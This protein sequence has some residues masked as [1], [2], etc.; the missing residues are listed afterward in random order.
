[1]KRLIATRGSPN[2]I[3]KGV[4]P[5]NAKTKQLSGTKWLSRTYKDMRFHNFLGNESITWKFNLSKAPWQGGQFGRLIGLTKQTLYT[6]IAKAQG[7]ERAELEEVMVDIEV[8]LNSRPLTYI[9]DH[10]ARQPL[11]LNSILLGC[12]VVLPTEQKVP[13]EDEGEVF[14]KQQKYV[15]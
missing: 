5:D 9:E 2:S 3:T 11:T 13:S 10:I 6:T 12:Y 15:L 8:N 1:M 7:R 14:R 4:Y